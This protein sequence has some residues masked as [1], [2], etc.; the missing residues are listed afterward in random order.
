[1]KRSISFLATCLLSCFLSFSS[2][3]NEA[4]NSAGDKNDTAKN[5]S[6]PDKVAQKD[7]V[8]LEVIATDICDCVS[9]YESELSSDAKDKLIHADKNAEVDTSWKLLSAKDQEVYFSEGKK[10]MSCITGLFQKYPT[11]QSLD[12]GTGKKLSGVLEEHCSEFAA[13]LVAPGK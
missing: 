8:E 6:K 13:A 1:M 10:A 2:C 5:I 12:K 4:K 7:Q 9:N 11:L 3:S